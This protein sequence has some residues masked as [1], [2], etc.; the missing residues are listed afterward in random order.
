MMCSGIGQYLQFRPL[1]DR[2]RFVSFPITILHPLLVNVFLIII[3]PII[4]NISIVIGGIIGMIVIACFA[5][6]RRQE[7]LDGLRRLS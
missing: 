2:L 6:S 1:V 7:R 4:D 3:L 5:Y